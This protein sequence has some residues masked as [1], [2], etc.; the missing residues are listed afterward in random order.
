MVAAALLL[1]GEGPAARRLRGVLPLRRATNSART[2]RAPDGAREK[3]ARLVRID[4]RRGLLVSLALASA[5][6]G[7]LIAVLRG[8]SGA[9]VF[10]LA[11]AAALGTASVLLGRHRK[12]PTTSPLRVAAGCDLLAAGLR[13]G[14]PPTALLDEMATEFEEPA[15]EGLREVSRS[16]SLGAD[17]ATGWEP[18]ARHAETAEL[19]R[20]ARRSLGSGSGLARVAAEIAVRKRAAASDDAVAHTERTAVRVT[21]PLGLCFLPAFFCLGVLPTVLGMVHRLDLHS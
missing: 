20:A 13:A 12:P 5:V 4:V 9:A 7:C 8:T 19:A 10:P 15:A 6:G 17:P 16:L 3:L 1:L 14:L 11:V 18:A 2:S 21:A